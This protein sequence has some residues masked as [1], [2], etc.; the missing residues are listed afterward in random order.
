MAFELIS[1]KDISKWRNALECHSKKD[2]CHTPEYHSSYEP[3]TFQSEAFLFHFQEG[4]KSLSYPFML[5]PVY[6]GTAENRKRTEYYDINSVYG[7]SGPLLNSDDEE[8]KARAWSSFDK[9]ALENKVLCEFIRFSV[10]LENHHWAHP[11]CE[12]SMNRPISIA[13]LPS[14]SD[15]YFS[16]L[17]SKTRNMIRRAK[18][19]GYSSRT[20]PLSEGLADFRKLYLDTMQRNGATD[21]FFYDDSYYD[22]YLKMPSDEV[23]LNAVYKDEEMVGAAIGLLNSDYVFYH[24]GASF[25]EA[26]RLGAG[27]LLLFELADHCIKKGVKFFN[28]GGGRTTKDDDALFRFKKSNGTDVTNFYIGK[29]I[30]DK[31]SYDELKV[32]WQKENP[33]KKSN[34]LQFYR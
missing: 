34:F 28:V 6:L 18:R 27:N 17:P 26:S 3:N 11:Q 30:L 4:S 10:F 21:F 14:E 1:A 5:A 20:I 2:V 25:K 29:R 7:F 8:F 16:L 24:L 13:N 32:E 12:V 33:E 19:E 15:E 31:D 23:C 22:W 9:W